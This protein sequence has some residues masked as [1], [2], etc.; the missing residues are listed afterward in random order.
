MLSGFSQVELHPKELNEEGVNWIFVID[1]LN[2]CFWS[3]ASD[4]KWTVTYQGKPYTGYFAL[5]AA[6]NRALDEG[7]KITTPSYYSQITEK[8]LAHI[9]RGDEGCPSVALLK[10]RRQCLHQVGLALIEKYDG[11]FSQVIEE[12]KHSAVKL[13]DLIVND[14]ECFRD[15][16]VY[17]EKRVGIYKRAQILIGDIWACGRGKDL[18]QFD[19]IFELTMFADYRVPQVLVDFGAMSYSTE[20]EQL[21]KKGKPL[22]AGIKIKKMKKVH[23][24]LGILANSF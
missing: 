15:E 3:P 16:A 7:Y 22:S 14:F 1:T 12:S 2:F 13:L 20:L 4:N 23:K 6:V 5:C 19:D 24:R 18:G 9:L 11:K 10:E 21:L 8:D 17:C